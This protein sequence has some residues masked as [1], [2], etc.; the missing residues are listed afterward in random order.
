MRAL[1]ENCANATFSKLT[2][3][4]LTTQS[5]SDKAKYLCNAAKWG[6]S[7]FVRCALE[8]NIS[9]NVRGGGV[10]NWPALVEAALTGRTH[11]LTLLL[12]GGADH[13]VTTGDGFTALFAATEGGHVQCVQLLLAAGADANKADDWLGRTPLM[14]SI[15]VRQAE[16]MKI[17]LPVSDLQAKDRQGRTALHMCIT[18][19]YKEGFELLL[20]LVSDVAIDCRISA[21]LDEH[22]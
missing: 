10:L 7:N 12:E 5:T 11:I 6:L 19:A 8:A 16:C 17:L 2:V 4:R 15:F 9:A 20:P 22:E 21:G 3:L 13:S 1:D 18:T 14:K